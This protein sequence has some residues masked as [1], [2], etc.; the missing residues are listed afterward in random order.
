MLTQG[1]FLFDT[2]TQNYECFISL[3]Q[4]LGSKFIIRSMQFTNRNSSLIQKYY[5]YS[6]INYEQEME[7]NH[8]SC[9]FYKSGDSIQFVKKNLGIKLYLNNRLD[10]EIISASRVQIA[11]TFSLRFRKIVSQ[12]VFVG[13]KRSVLY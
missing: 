8:C 6:F 3:Y 1:S 12:Y 5:L 11:D 2:A 13:S 9:L 4:H 10:N 7:A